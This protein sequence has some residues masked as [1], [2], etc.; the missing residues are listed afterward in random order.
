MSSSIALI[1]LESR[2]S[3]PNTIAFL[4]GVII[5][6]VN[7][8]DLASSG[9]GKPSTISVSISTKYVLGILNSKISSWSFSGKPSMK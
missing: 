9:F 3:R 5:E 1:C 2:S 6:N 8:R 4:S 7:I